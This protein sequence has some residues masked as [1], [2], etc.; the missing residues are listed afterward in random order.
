MIRAGLAAAL[1]L[2]LA[3]PA[4]AQTLPALYDVAGVAANDRLNIRAAPSANAAILGGL[5]PDATGIEVV[6]LT[7]TGWAQ[8][9]LAEGTGFVALRFLRPEGGPPWTALQSRLTCLGTEPFWALTYGPGPGTVHIETPERSQTVTVQQ[10]WPGSDL[11][12]AALA[13]DRGFVTLE[14]RICS[15][16]MS[17]RVYGIAAWVFPKAGPALGGCCTLAP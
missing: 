3:L 11:A 16:G 10:T 8:V 6:A 17:D 5:A 14:G 1:C 15:D 12:P 4:A 13:T 7:G 2:G 9:N